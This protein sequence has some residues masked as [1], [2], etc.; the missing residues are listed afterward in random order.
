MRKGIDI[1]AAFGKIGV[2]QVSE[3][4]YRSADQHGWK[5]SNPSEQIAAKANPDHRHEYAK[6][7]RCEG[8][9]VFRIVQILKVEGKVEAHPDI[10]ETGVGKDATNYVHHPPPDAAAH[11][12]RR[13]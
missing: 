9:L 10:L 8:N 2:H 7:F 4:S 12:A 11:L 6:Y 3:R 13:G 1:R 5:S